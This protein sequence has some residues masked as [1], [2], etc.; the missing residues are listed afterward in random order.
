MVSF[1]IQWIAIALAILFAGQGICAGKKVASDKHGYRLELPEGWRIK[2]YPN[3][4]NLVI[5]DIEKGKASMNMRLYD[6]SR[7][8]GRFSDFVSRYT[9]D[10]EEQNRKAYGSA[11]EPGESG[12]RKHGKARAYVCSYKSTSRY[13]VWLLKQYL[14]PAANRMKVYVFQS[15]CPWE[16]RGKLEPEMDAVFESLVLSDTR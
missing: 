3:S 2:R 15:G 5:A 4:K 12:F 1:R 13:G 10:F 11:L 14:L 6:M 16:T 7:F 9:A 8:E